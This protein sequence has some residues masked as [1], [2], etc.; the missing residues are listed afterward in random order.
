MFQFPDEDERIANVKQTFS[1]KFGYVEGLCRAWYDALSDKWFSGLSPEVRNLIIRLVMQGMRQ[2]RSTIEECR[3]AD[4]FCGDIV[5]R[6]LFETTVAVGFLLK[7]DIAVELFPILDKQT[8]RPKT[9]DKGALKHRAAQ[10]T[11]AGVD[12]TTE[13][14]VTLYQA[15]NAFSTLKILERLATVKGV[16]VDSGAESPALLVAR[17]KAATFENT[18]GDEWSYALKKSG[19]YSG[20]DSLED[21]TALV[22]PHLLDV[23]GVIYK[24]QSGKG[25][26]AGALDLHDWFSDDFEIHMALRVGAMLV[27]LCIN[28]LQTYLGLGEG[29]ALDLEPW[30]ENFHAVFDEDG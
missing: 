10:S 13:F 21:T 29:V 4:G 25:H 20:L 2:F 18:V 7:P 26:A 15:H 19:W 6:S 17:A 30:R 24:A 23:Y 11:R 27:L 22:C 1:S 14:R 12:F 5:A 16:A 8:K 3:R 28:I 9:T